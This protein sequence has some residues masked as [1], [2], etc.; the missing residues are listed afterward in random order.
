VQVIYE[1]AGR[2]REFAALAAN[3]YRGCA[4]GCLYCYAPQVIKLK[5]EEFV[6]G[7]RP[8]ENVL[9]YLEKDA[10][11]FRGDDREILL[12]LTSDPYQPLETALGLTRR[13]IEILIEN[14]LRFAILTKAG[15]RA[16][17]DFDLMSRYPRCRFGTTLIFTLETDAQKWE[18]AA[19]SI[20]ERIRSLRTAHQNGIRTWV[21]LEP[22]I[23]AAQAL[24]LIKPL[25]PIV[26]QW[27][28]GRLNYRRPD[29]AVDWIAFR[30]EALELLDGLGAD[31]CMKK[32]LTEL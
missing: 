31:Y 28:I 5:R 15:R 32:S 21:S 2:A 16:S 7:A 22:V 4:H 10:R 23:D 12:S 8:R 6:A 13:A 27:N 14:E 29:R 24:S 30:K 3:L 19:A 1:P 11:R 9:K 18:P 26:E 25:H 17:R 20:A